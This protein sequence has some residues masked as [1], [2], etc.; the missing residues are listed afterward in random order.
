[1][2]IL[3]LFLLLNSL[4]SSSKPKKQIKL[5]KHKSQKTKLLKQGL[6]YMN[7]DGF[8]DNDKKKEMSLTQE[9]RSLNQNQEQ[10]FKNQ[11]EKTHDIMSKIKLMLEAI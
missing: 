3:F 8:E 6:Q 9:A 7:F 10:V 11:V 4:L 1:M 2:K 5:L